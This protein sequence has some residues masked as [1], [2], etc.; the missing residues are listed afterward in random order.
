MYTH[1]GAIRE[2]FEIIA[3]FPQDENELFHMFPSAVYP[4]TSIQMEEQTKLR[5]KP[6]VIIH[7]QEVVAHA[8]LYG[9]EGSTCWI[10]NV[11]IA[12]SYRGKGVVQYL[13]EVMEGIA[14]EELS[15]THI[16]LTCHSSNTRGIFLYTKLGYIPYEISRF[17][18]PTGELI[19]GIRMKKNI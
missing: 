12:P 11:I 3:T 7:N 15:V 4:L 9:H 19:A 17:N 16:N 1:R 13:V 5:L 18:K 2:D 6:T 14:K 8:N 10:G